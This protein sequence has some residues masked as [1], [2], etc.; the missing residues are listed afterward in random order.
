MSELII[1]WALSKK[2]HLTLHEENSTISLQRHTEALL[3][4]AQL[5]EHPPSNSQL[6]TWMRMGGSSLNHFQGAL[7]IAP[8]N[9][10]LWLLQ[11][12]PPDCST[13]QLLAGLESLLNQRDI[14]RSVAARL[15]R[16]AHSIIPRPLGQRSY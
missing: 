2:A 3:L 7:A 8:E 6:Q 1:H 9:G 13:A 12:L 16:P 10:A 15:A 4:S 11:A 5:T 14:W